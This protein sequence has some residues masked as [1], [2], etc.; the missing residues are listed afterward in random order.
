MLLR[1]YQVE[2]LA[3]IRSAYRSGFRRVVYASPTGSG[4]SAMLEYMLGTTN[5]SALI[6]AHRIELVEMIAERLPV[7]FGLVTAGSRLSSERVQVGMVQTVTRRLA[8]LPKFQ[9]VISDE[10]HLAMSASW[11]RILNHYSEAY[12]LG[13]SATPCRLDGIGLG[14]IYQSIV[15]GPS[16]R[17]LVDGGYLVPPRVFAPASLVESLHLRGG[18]FALDEAAQQL[19]TGRITG[20]AA[21]QLRKHGPGEQAVAFCSTVQHAQDVAAH[22][23]AAN[24][25]AAA[26]DGGMPGHQRRGILGAFYAK[27]LQV[28]CNVDILTT[29]WD[30][31]PLGA[32]IFLRPTTSLALYLQ[33]VGRV[34]R[35]NPATGK[36]WGLILDHVG[37]TVRHGMPDARREW[38]LDGRVKRATPPA[39]KT[40]PACFA[41]FAPAPSCPQCGRDLRQDN[42]AGGR[43]SSEAPGE[44]VEI[45]RASAEALRALPLKQLLAL[46]QS[47]DDIRR[48]GKARGYHH[49]WVN[50][51]LRHRA[52]KYRARE[53][54]A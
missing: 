48:I 40:C 43:R 24:I 21:A 41:A 33:M 5:K 27:Q 16:I 32:L 38:A 46:A 12:Q 23:T 2:G 22:F 14:T 11:S 25:P 51:V 1:P 17:E 26:I 29:G 31:P 18:E 36:R 10:C 54:R 37:N 52:A 13:L 30:Y 35:V 34:L 20:D 42:G 4:K 50:H 44:L 47:E 3:G 49:Q 7:S 45:D 6:L 28:L 39:V 8:D 19:N 53:D 15:H 9:W